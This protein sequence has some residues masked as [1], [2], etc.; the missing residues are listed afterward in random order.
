MQ[1]NY[2]TLGCQRLAFCWTLSQRF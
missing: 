2:Y 1:I